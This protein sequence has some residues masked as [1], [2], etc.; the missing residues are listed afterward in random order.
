[1]NWRSG[2]SPGEAGMGFHDSG[3]IWI[4]PPRSAVSKV[5]RPPGGRSDPSG[6]AAGGAAT[7]APAGGAGRADNK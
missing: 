5:P 2:D 6:A 4:K 7:T 3:L 1:M